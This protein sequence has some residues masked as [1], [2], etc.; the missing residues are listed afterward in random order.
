MNAR[1]GTDYNMSWPECLRKFGVG[2]INENGL[3]QPQG[4]LFRPAAY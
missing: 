2:K 3:L 4:L 1:V